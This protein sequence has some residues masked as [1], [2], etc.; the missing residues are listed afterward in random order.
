STMPIYEYRCEKCGHRFERWQKMS[1]PDPQ[2]CPECKTQAVER[3]ISAVGFRLKGSGW[4]ETDFKQANRHN[5]AGEK[6]GASG[7]SAASSGSGG[8]SKGP[9]SGKGVE[10]K[11]PTKDK[12]SDN[13]A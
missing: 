5:I 6:G 1:D 13:A 8:T 3:L 11:K 2:Q 4:Y 10:K 7:K 9:S 12:A